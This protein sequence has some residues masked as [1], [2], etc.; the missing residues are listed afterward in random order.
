MGLFGHMRILESGI[1]R[2]PD[3]PIT[4][5]PTDT[6]SSCEPIT[7]IAADTDTTDF[8]CP[9]SPRT[10]NSRIGLVG[11]LRIHG[12]EI[13]EPV[14]GAPTFTHQDRLHCPHCPRT[15]RHR[16]GL[17][18]HMRI[19]ESGIERNPD[20]PTTS[21]TTTMPSP[22]LASSPCEPTTTSTTINSAVADADTAD[23]SCLHCPRTFTFHIGL[24]GHLRSHSTEAGEPVPGAPTYTY[25]TRLHCL[26]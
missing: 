18:G 17:F 3:S 2:P 5:N 26:H 6:S 9:H 19:H 11:H 7:V 16:M 13:G 8:T 21:N 20:K 22:T 12:T 24:V 23:F 4:P 10:F 1:D 14:P 25:R 15:F